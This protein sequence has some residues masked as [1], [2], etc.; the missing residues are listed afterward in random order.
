MPV[1]NVVTLPELR[2]EALARPRLTA[3]LLL[4]FAVIALTITLVG[5][6]GVIAISVT[7]RL[8]EFGLWMAL[9]AS[10]AQVLTVVMKEGLALVAAG[11]LVGIV[12]SFAATQSLHAYLYET[13][14]GDPAT[15]A[16]VCLTLLLAGLV[17]CLVPAVH[18]TSADP[19]E[20][21]RA[22]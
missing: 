10:R 3:A 7:H 19:I 4:I 21:L 18:A 2:Q 11:L 5:V 9:G 8:K 13:P 1:E 17:S 15:L 20:S 22:E 12:C 16:A 6:S 14:A